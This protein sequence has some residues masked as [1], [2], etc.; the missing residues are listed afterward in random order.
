[1]VRR[2]PRST[3][4]DTLSPY[5]PLFRSSDLRWHGSGE[6]QRLVPRRQGADDL[7][8][9]ADEAHVEHAVG[10]VEDEVRDAVETHVA[11]VQ[12]VHEASGRGDQNVDPAR[13]RAHLRPLGDAA[14]DDGVA[15]AQVAAV[16]LERIADLHGELTRQI[17]SLMRTSYAVF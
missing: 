2:P 11:L 16:G 9:I 8:D 1:M 13:Q 15:Q 5:T 10:L 6:Q 3:R 4:T 14:E 7:S 12:Q 17:Q